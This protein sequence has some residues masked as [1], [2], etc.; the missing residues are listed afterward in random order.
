MC[1]SSKVSCS[2]PCPCVGLGDDAGAG[3]VAR[4]LMRGLGR[5][6]ARGDGGRCDVWRGETM[7]GRR[8]G[9]WRGHQRDGCCCN[10]RKGLDRVEATE[11]IHTN[12]HS[13]ERTGPGT[14]TGRV[15]ISGPARRSFCPLPR[16]DRCQA[17][18]SVGPVAQRRAW[19]RAMP[20]VITP[21]GGE[22]PG[23]TSIVI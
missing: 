2:C 13:G 22:A 23:Q 15:F 9:G 17:S 18:L 19:K 6:L 1:A 10:T 20:Y 16:K 11:S 8:G 4:C 3:A 14:K 5:P 21:T 12:A 7:R